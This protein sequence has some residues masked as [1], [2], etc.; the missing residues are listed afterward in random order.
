MTA[1]GLMLAALAMQPGQPP[2]TAPD[3]S[4]DDIVVLAHRMRKVRWEFEAKGGVLSKCEIRRTSGS[5]RVDRLVCE[6]SAQCAAERPDLGDSALIPCI[7]ERVGRL[8][9]VR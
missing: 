9:A 4:G 6:A 8:D 7:R 3:G 5:A 2:T 1:I